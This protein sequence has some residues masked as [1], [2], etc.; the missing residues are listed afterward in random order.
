MSVL[1][2]HS[3]LWTLAAVDKPPGAA[4]ATVTH[5]IRRQSRLKFYNNKN[6]GQKMLAEVW[7]VIYLFIY[8]LD[9]ALRKQETVSGEQELNRRHQG[10]E[11]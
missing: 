6:K 4:A 1:W 11:F 3:Q 7:Q 10:A 9:L 8:F 5:G 2:N